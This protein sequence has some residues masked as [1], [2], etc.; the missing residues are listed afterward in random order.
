M[1]DTH[2]I[3]V[4]G[5]AGYIGSACVKALCEQGYAVVAL[6]NLSKGERHYVD[7]RATFV[8]VDI[9]DIAALRDVFAIHRPQAVIHAAA[10]KSVSESEEKLEEYFATNVTGTLNVLVQAA[11]HGTAHVIFS[12]T[13]AVY[14]A[15]SDGV[16]AE[17]TPLA[18]MSVYGTSKMLAEQLITEFARTKKLPSYTI[19]RYF[20]V[21]GD[22]DVHFKD[23]DPQ[24]VFPILANALGKGLPFS[25]FGDDYS[26]TDGTC[27]R[28][29]IHIADIVEAHL[30]ALSTNAGG[31]YNLGSGGG[32]SVKEIVTALE[33]VS[34]KSLKTVIAPRRSGDPAMVLADATKAQ[35]DLNWKPGCSL[36]MMVE[37]T[38]MVYN[39]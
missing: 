13:A 5:G 4:T 19:F 26:T 31:I 30:R 12:S 24:N 2:T 14:E 10:L 32:Y 22:A 33:E 28:D 9:L 17:D 6:D 29:Y 1:N 34:G 21:V 20:N 37:D 16:C 7:E 39:V 27:V 35:N 25:I 38:L 11:A 8:E 15:P 3:L 18:P 23:A 36:R